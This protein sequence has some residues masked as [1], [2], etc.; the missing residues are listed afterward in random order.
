MRE[1]VL[2][3]L[4]F[5]ESGSR[6]DAIRNHDITFDMHHLHQ[7]QIKRVGKAQSDR[8]QTRV[9]HKFRQHTFGCLISLPLLFSGLYWAGLPTH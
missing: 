2:I 7:L 8:G 9:V 3:A 1:G 5:E 4:C 6:Q